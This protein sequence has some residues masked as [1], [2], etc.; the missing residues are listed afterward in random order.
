[1]LSSAAGNRRP[2]ASQMAV[3]I[4][5]VF[6]LPSDV[7]GDPSCSRRGAAMLF[8]GD[9]TRAASAAA[10]CTP[11]RVHLLGLVATI[12]GRRRIATMPVY[13]MLR[14]LNGQYGA[15]VNPRQMVEHSGH[16]GAEAATT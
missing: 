10:S 12:S 15:S 4:K 5:G 16:M 1:M 6:R 13:Q 2:K 14:G 7:I 9:C 11:T 3:G 8:V